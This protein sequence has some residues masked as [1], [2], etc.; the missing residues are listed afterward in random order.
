GE[1]AAAAGLGNGLRGRQA[2]RLAALRDD[3]PGLLVRDVLRH[4]PAEEPVGERL[5]RADLVGVDEDA[6]LVSAVLEADDDVLRDIDETSREVS[7]VGR[8]N[9]RVGETLS[10]TVR[11]GGVL[12]GRSVTAEG[13]HDREGG[14]EA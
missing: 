1:A 13:R 6:V 7:G 14:G 10:A 11:R 8:A 9:G 4:E 5:D 2:D 12:R 3:L